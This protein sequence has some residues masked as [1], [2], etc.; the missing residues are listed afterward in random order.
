MT[1]NALRTLAA[2]FLQVASHLDSADAPK[3]Q[4]RRLT[5]SLRRRYEA[6]HSKHHTL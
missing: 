3:G 5:T 2:F 1:A 6:L 4:A